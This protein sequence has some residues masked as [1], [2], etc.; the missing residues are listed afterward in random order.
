MSGICLITY[1]PLESAAPCHRIRDRMLLALT[2]YALVRAGEALASDQASLSVPTVHPDF[3]TLRTTPVEVTLLPAPGTFTVPPVVDKQEFSA[4]EFRPRK[5]S[6]ASDAAA[7]VPGES[8]MLTGTTVWQRLSDYKSH[9]KVRLLTLWETSASTVSIQT[10]THG[11][12]SLQWTSRYMNRGGPTRG[13]FDRL[14]AVS[15][16]GAGNS[17]RGMGHSNSSQTPAKPT[18]SSVTAASPK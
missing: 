2:L 3:G 14:F 16:A 15:L 18:S 7:G 4:T 17:L 11:D 13:L 12:P 10:T 6:A 5:H 9:D 1:P 8:P